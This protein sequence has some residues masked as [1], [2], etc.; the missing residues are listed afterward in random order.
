[1]KIILLPE[2][3]AN[4]QKQVPLFLSRTL[5]SQQTAM[6]DRIQ[7]PELKPVNNFIS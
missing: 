4:D 1:M 7:Y 5:H 3:L 2:A 6:Q